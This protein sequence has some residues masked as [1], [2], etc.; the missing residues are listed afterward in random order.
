MK[1]L[2]LISSPRGE[3]SFSI[4][5]GQVIVDRLLTKYPGS[6]V[7]VRNLADQPLPHLHDTHL[8][9]FMT[10][11]EQ[12][13]PELAEA[14]KASDSAIADLVAADV[15]VIGVPMYNFAIH[16]VLKTWLDHVLRA[17]V[18]FRYTDGGPEGLL[19]GKRAYLAISTG[20]I[21]SEG[22]MKAYDFTEPYLRQTLGFVGI[23]DVTAYRVE[24]V[25]LPNIQE[26]ALE[27]AVKKIRV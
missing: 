3:S 13:S 6:D 1:I 7:V 25:K 9:A 27:D 16:S 23:S 21:Y 22:P 12:R 8:H 10:P 11:P 14:I 4:K 2:H 24:G 26:H 19:K 18:T 20:G 15:V 17:G 5:L